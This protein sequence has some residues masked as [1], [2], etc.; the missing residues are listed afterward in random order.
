MNN[1]TI[2]AFNRLILNI[3]MKTAFLNTLV[4]LTSTVVMFSCGGVEPVPKEKEAYIGV[5]QSPSGFQIQILPEGYANV[6]QPMDS[7]HPE[8]S[9]LRVQK[10]NEVY[11]FGF[12][13]IFLGD[14][15]IQIKKPYTDGKRYTINRRPYYDADT[16]KMV[17]NSVT[18]RKYNEE[19]FMMD[20]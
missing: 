10:A 5:W 19:H 18:V 17:I 14:S 3:P 6:F 2:N 7:L 13:V 11:N 9:K 4:V 1:I 8:Y 16:M 15:A 20:M 12:E